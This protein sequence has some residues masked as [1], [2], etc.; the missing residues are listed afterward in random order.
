MTEKIT[1]TSN[2]ST[3]ATQGR[4]AGPLRVCSFES[5]RAAEMRSL[6]EKQGGIA[7]VAPSM[8]EV[9]LNENSAAFEF[10]QELLAGKI[11]TVVFMTGVG[12]RA[13][14]AALETR[15][16]REEV[17]A[18]LQRCRIVVRGPKP[19]A[20]LREWKVRI[21]YKAPEPNTWRELLTLLDQESQVAGQRIAVQEYGEPNGQFYEELRQQGADVMPVPVYRWELPDDTGPLKRAVETTRSGGFDV[22]MFTSA[23]QVRNVLE[24]AET[25]GLKHDWQTAAGRCI[26]ASIGPTTSEA[27]ADAGLPVHLEASPPKMGQLV[28]LV[29]SAG[30]KAGDR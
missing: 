16:T 25:E 10:A 30:R 6:I 13:L 1:S 15:Y 18:A 20:V 21:D 29:F 8:Q 12:A 17:F 28:R 19:T 9:P 11:D 27:L 24:V 7:T 23:Q 5:R 2:A 26:I 4:T 14:L 22:L 3:P